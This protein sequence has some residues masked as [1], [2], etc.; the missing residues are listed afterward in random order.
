VDERPPTP[1][2]DTGRVDASLVRGAELLGFRA[3]QLGVGFL[4]GL[5]IARALGPTGRAEYALPLALATTVLVLSH[6]SM[7]AAIARLLARGEAT[8]VQLTGLASS[9]SLVLGLI[10]TGLCLGAGFLLPSDVLGD[11]SRTALVL[12]AASVAPMLYAL[13][14]AAIMF[15]LGQ[16]RAYGTIQALT[17]VG[18]LVLLLLLELSTGLSPESVLALNVLLVVITGLAMAVCLA[19]RLS[20]GGLYPTLDRDL[21]SRALRTGVVMHPSSLALFLNLRIDLFLVAA[22]LGA[23]EAGLYSLAVVLAELVYVAGATLGIAARRDQADLPEQESAEYTADV[24]RQGLALSLVLAAL[25]AAL[26]YPFVTLV[27]G[28]EWSAAAAPLAVLV[29][30]SVVLTVHGPVWNLLVRVGRPSRIS[31]AA[32]V[33]VLFNV[34]L[35]LAMIPWLGL[36]GAAISSVLSYLLATALLLVQMRDATSIPIGQAIRP[37]RPEDA[38]RRAARRLSSRRRGG[39]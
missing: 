17:A 1:P 38:V 2:P 22:Y 19:V 4:S 13:L 20:P 14:A 16:L 12:A 36:V 3:V 28:D 24:T 32:I 26:S 23:E 27:Y 6:L 35:N 7:E 18:Q 21:V 5:V 30:A 34:L 10:G 29:F 11:A 39:S 9:A 37:P 25:V 8:A 33:G 15:R 31:I